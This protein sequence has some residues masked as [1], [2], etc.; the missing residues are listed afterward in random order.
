MNILED[1]AQIA[2]ARPETLKNEK[3]KG[4]KVVGY[5]GRFVPEELIY[6][7]G[8]VPFLICRGGEPEPPEATL[9]YMIHVIN[10]FTRGQIG[11]Y[12]LDSDPVAPILDLIITQCSDCHETRL[13]DLV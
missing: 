3:E 1:L 7:S 10:P 11:Y 13:A 9:P 12:L 4:V 2:R 8:A 6:A 5:T